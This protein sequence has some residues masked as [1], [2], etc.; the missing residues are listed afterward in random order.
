MKVFKIKSRTH[1][2]QQ[3]PF[4]I[5]M[6]RGAKFQRYYFSFKYISSISESANITFLKEKLCPKTI[7]MHIKFFKMNF[8]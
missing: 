5:S 2:Q 3:N 8:Y 6:T 1:Q 7:N 4:E